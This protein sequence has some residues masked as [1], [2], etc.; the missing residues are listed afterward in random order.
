MLLEDFKQR[1]GNYLTCAL[2]ST[3]WV[4]LAQLNC[5]EARVEAERLIRRV[6]QQKQ[7][8]NSD[9]NLE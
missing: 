6:L 8:R 3:F 9:D 7:P 5:R 1:I 4:P 2:Q